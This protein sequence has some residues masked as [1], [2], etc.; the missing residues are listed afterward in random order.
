M[1]DDLAEPLPKKLSE[2]EKRERGW[3][4]LATVNALLLGYAILHKLLMPLARALGPETLSNALGSVDWW[5]SFHAVMAIVLAKHRRRWLVFLGGVGVAFSAVRL[6]FSVYEVLQPH[7]AP[8][9]EFLSTFMTEVLTAIFLIAALW[10]VWKRPGP[11]FRFLWPGVPFGLGLGFFLTI[12]VP[13]LTTRVKATSLSEVVGQER[14]ERTAVEFRKVP[15]SSACASAEVLWSPAEGER[16][17]RHESVI[18]EPCGFAESLLRP[19]GGLRIEN[20]SGRFLNVRMDALREESGL[21]WK[22]VRNVGLFPDKSY[23]IEVALIQEVSLLR[24]HSDSWVEAGVVVVAG[25]KSD[26]WPK[27]EVWVR[28]NR[29]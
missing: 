5:W 20:R 21:K 19:T 27:E 14:S 18:I 16:I 23:V 15:P 4:F 2:A 7:R 17:P 12:T 13:H 29:Q 25:G 22:S 3:R 9:W 11:W 6:G 26:T 10:W 1:S 24:I 8:S 28:A